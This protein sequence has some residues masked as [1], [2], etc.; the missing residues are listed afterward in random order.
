MS[1]L[2]TEQVMEAAPGRNVAVEKRSIQMRT[3]KSPTNI[4]MCVDRQVIV[5]LGQIAGAV[6]DV[7]EK[8]GTLPDG[9]AKTSLL[10]QGEFE[11]VNYE[12]GEVTQAFAAYLPGYFAEA[13]KAGLAK[14]NGGVLQ[15]GIEVVAEPTGLDPKTNMPKGIPFAYGVRNLMGR[16]ADSPLEDVKRR[17]AKLNMLR[18]TPPQT[19]D[20]TE[21]VML[22]KDANGEM[23]AVASGE[24]TAEQPPLPGTEP[25]QLT[26]RN[27][28][29]KA[30]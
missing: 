8:P 2:T 26:G 9:T 18:L 1:G 10:A 16:R 17:L 14:T 23:E 20:T 5:P 13:L 4:K 30:A 15:I 22:P 7:V 27:K 29:A 3:F 6:Y 21:P 12:T 24:D 19:I 25:A 28:P 11:A